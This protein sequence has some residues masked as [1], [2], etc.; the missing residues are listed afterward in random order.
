MICPF[1]QR[2][3]LTR[4]SVNSQCV[5]IQVGTLARAAAIIITLIVEIISAVLI[6]LS[7]AC[8]CLIRVCMPGGRRENF[9]DE[10][11]AFLYMY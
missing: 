10:W 5:N 7:L 6:Y 2:S 9:I 8:N 11:Q 4:Y 3:Q 1:D